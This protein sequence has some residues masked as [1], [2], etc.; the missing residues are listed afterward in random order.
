MINFLTTA[1]ANLNPYGLE[2]MSNKGK[3]LDVVMACALSMVCLLF[4]HWLVP[5]LRRVNALNDAILNSIGG[6][7]A[8]GYVFLHAIPGFIGNLALVKQQVTTNFMQDEKN[9]L[10]VVFLFV[11]L[12]FCVWYALE[13][14][15]HD[16]SKK[17]EEAGGFVYVSH[18]LIMMYVGF[19][20]TLIM[21]VLARESLYGMIL[22]TVI[23]AFHFVLED[24]SLS[25]HFPK[26]FKYSGRYLIMLGVLAGWLFSFYV[27]TPVHLIMT[28]FMGAFLAGG[29]ILTTAKTEFSLLEGRSHFPTFLA[30]LTFKSLIV[31]IMLLLENIG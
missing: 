14:L 7:L 18:V 11:I 13:K 30:S 27:T 4:V 29:L 1:G 16:H 9:L 26:R 15:A 20:T 22:F 21:P 10:F 24:H 28:T 17:G 3:P 5:R 25:Y 12:G 6:G 8:L 31:F 19:L 23:M 2:I